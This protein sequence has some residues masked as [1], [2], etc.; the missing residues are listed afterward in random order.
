M[1]RN[2]KPSRFRAHA[3]TPR[4]ALVESQGSLTIDAIASGGDGV[5]RIDGLACFVPR[6]A[7]GDRAQVAYVTHARHARG[8]VLQLLDVASTRV[9]PRC[10]HYEDDRCG[11]CQV[12]HLAANV[13]Q[14]ARVQIV[15]DALRRIGGRDIGVPELTS[16][17][18]WEYRGRLTL[19]LL[20]RSAGWIG[21]LHPHDD[22]SRVF[23]LTECPISHPALVQAWL[24]L[25]PF[26]RGLPD[27]PKLRL[28]L[29]LA[30]S[31][32]DAPRVALVIEGGALWPDGVAWARRVVAAHPALHA[33]WWA[34]VSGER[35]LL[36]GGTASDGMNDHAH[37]DAHHD[38]HHDALD[39]VIE[40]VGQRSTPDA[41]ID[42][43]APYGSEAVEALAFAQVN[44]EVAAALHAF[45]LH[46]VRG[47]DPETAID[48]YAGVG[49][50][51]EALARDGVRV[52]AIESDPAA[53]RRAMF[54]LSS[55]DAALQSR[56]HVLTTT[57]EA[58]LSQALP[59]DVVVLNPPRRGV[60]GAVTAQLAQA[61]RMGVRG[62]VYVSCDPATLA[63]DLARLGAW[64]IRELRCFDMFPQT[65]HVETVCV[66]VPENS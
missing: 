29:R 64:R 32:P 63:R 50:L 42:D 62:I 6:T 59:A 15:R 36:H 28:G 48:G 38:A 14:A 33:I 34:R 56:V 3:R 2:R 52:T 49:M 7:P 54:R 19:T 10:H 24:A 66:L 25:A 58:G 13:Q 8:R 26:L 30:G 1:T 21:G 45:V 40:P 60:D 31:D 47:F 17:K 22:A 51:A 9:A 23:A 53:T 65:A 27:A 11:G 61:S 18:E 37:D 5:G 43:M 57:V 12:Q 20:K 46:Q 44:R 4:A 55:A 16:G 35:V 41:P 39:A